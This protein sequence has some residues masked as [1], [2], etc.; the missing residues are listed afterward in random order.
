MGLSFYGRD[1]GPIPAASF[2]E[3]FGDYFSLLL[4]LGTE[5]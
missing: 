4:I 1:T 3:R 5:D 2:D